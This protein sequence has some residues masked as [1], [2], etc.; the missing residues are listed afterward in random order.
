M[1]QTTTLILLLQV[2]IDKNILVYA[3]QRKYCLHTNEIIWERSEVKTRTQ[4]CLHLCMNISC[5]NSYSIRSRYIN[6]TNC[7]VSRVPCLDTVDLSLTLLTYNTASLT[8]PLYKDKLCDLPCLSV[9]RHNIYPTPER[10]GARPPQPHSDYSKHIL[11]TS[12]IYSYLHGIRIV[13]YCLTFASVCTN[14]DCRTTAY[15]CVFVKQK[16]NLQTILM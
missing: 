9:Y 1:R 7:L 15:Y 5:H 11:V 14:I 3:C 8:A 16:K 4:I 13:S 2:T 12:I 6:Q 10:E